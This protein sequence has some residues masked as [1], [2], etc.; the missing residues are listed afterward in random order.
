M[1][2]VISRIHNYKPELVFFVCMSF[3]LTG[4]WLGQYWMFGIPVIMTG[5]LFL[6]KNIHWSYY[7]YFLLMPISVEVELPGGLATDFPTEPFMWFLTG[8]G[9]LVF[10]IRCDQLDT[11]RFQNPVTVLLLF[12]LLWIALCIFFTTDKVVSGKWFLAKLWYVIPF[13]F[14]TYY[15][16]SDNTQFRRIL[17]FTFYPL[18]LVVLWILSRHYGYGF[19]FDTSNTVVY[20]IFRNHVNYAS[21]LVLFLP[22]VWYLI[23]SSGNKPE[24]YM[25][26]G[27]FAIF[28]IAVYFS[29]TRIAIL[30]LPIGVGAYFIIKWKWVKWAMAACFAGLIFII[31]FL[32]TENR[33]V[34]FAPDFEKTITHTEFDNLLDA[35]YKL[36]DISTMERVYRWV[37]GAHMLKERPFFGFGPAT[38]YNNY[39]D[40]TVSIF[41]TYV[42]D[43]PDHSGIHSYYLMT[44]VEQGLIGLIIFLLLIIVVL[45]TGEKV[46]HSVRVPETKQ[47]VMACIISVIII[48][49]INLINDTLEVDKIGPFFLMSLAIIGMEYSSQS[50]TK[51]SIH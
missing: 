22:F 34:N 27:A 43:N 11:R 20:P 8:A 2:A 21:T 4:L 47:K 38:F 16:V 31:S 33:Y 1:E 40:Y 25:L 3:I 12:H 32:V 29:Y 39:M 10:L 5:L 41:K 23:V 49:V 50:K 19:S 18:I 51:K 35:T 36:E 17:L 30:C 37:A 28:V 44:A 42:S 14:G 7:L 26:A 15:F 6:M 48:L 13:Y 46:Y 9:S 24:K 45:L